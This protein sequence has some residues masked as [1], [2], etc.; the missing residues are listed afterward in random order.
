[1]SLARSRSSSVA[2]FLAGAKAPMSAADQYIQCAKTMV[3]QMPRVVT[4]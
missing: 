4:S 3:R 1:M 2:F